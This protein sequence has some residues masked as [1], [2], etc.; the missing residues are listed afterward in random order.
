MS[1]P[2]VGPIQDSGGQIDAFHVGISEDCIVELRSG[3]VCASEV[4]VAKIYA[5]E[6]GIGEVRVGKYGFAETNVCQTCIAE[7]FAFEVSVAVMKR[8]QGHS[9]G[10]EKVIRWFG[11]QA[12]MGLPVK[13]V[14]AA[15]RLKATCGAVESEQASKGMFVTYTTLSAQ[16]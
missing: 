5:R 2:A 10:D 7:I 8:C 3:K 6:I 9:G 15:V 1:P 13:P 4:C 11:A 14:D 16:M 12:A